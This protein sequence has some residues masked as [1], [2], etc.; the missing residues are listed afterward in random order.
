MA[1]RSSTRRGLTALAVAATVSAL[2]PPTGSAAAAANPWTGVDTASA[3]RS[4]RPAEVHTDRFAGFTLDRSGMAGA[5]RGS[6]DPE[7]VLPT[8]SG[9]FERFELVD[10]PVMEPGLA[11]RHPE[12]RTYAGRGLDDPTATVRA[13]LT[14]LG[15]HAS[16]RSPRGQ[17]FVD[18]YFHGDQSLYASYYGHDLTAAEPLRETEVKHVARQVEAAATGSAVRLRTYRLALVTDPSYARYFGAENVTAA[19]ASLVNRVAQVYEDETAIRLLL[20][21]ATDKTN[22]NTDAEASRPNGPCGATACF[23]PEDL[24][25]C[26]TGTFVDNITAL[27]QLVG[28]GNYDVGHIAM[29]VRGGGAAAPGVG[30]QD[31]A[32]GCTGL[33][34]P[35]GDFFAVDYVAHEIGHQFGADH[36]FNGDQW[37]CGSGQR[38]AED[39]YEPGSGSSIMAYAGIC[40]QDNLQRHSDPYWS[41]RSLTEITSFTSAAPWSDDEVQNVSLRDFDGTDSFRLTFR[42]HRSAPITHG[43]GYTPETLKAAL[44]SILPAGAEVEV[45]GYGNNTY[46]RPSEVDDTGFQVTFGGTLA[47][48]DVRPLGIETTG[49]TALVGEAVQGGPE[50]NQGHR[51]TTTRNHRPV[52]TTAAHHTIP[53]RTPFALTGRAHDPDGDPVTYMWEQN[54]RGGETGTSL[55]DNRKTNGPL[56]RQ[57]GTAATVTD[58]DALTYYSP[59]ENTA[60]PNPTRV[61]PDLAQI[62]ANNTNAPTGTCPTAPPPPAPETGG[63]TNLSPELIDCYSEFLPTPDWVGITEDRTLHFKLTARDG[64]QGGGGI[65]SADTAL[66]ITPTA[67]P[68]LV[69]SQ[70][71]TPTYK[72]GSRQ[73]V[74]WTVAGTNTT[75]INTTA[76]RITFSTDGGLTFPHTL[77]PRTRND[78]TATVTLP[79]LQTTKGR[80][81]VEAIGNIYFDLNDTDIT[82]TR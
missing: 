69:T 39:S 65:G 6:T 42:G 52:V 27:G 14:P 38:S 18:P 26:R 3:A 58:S 59:G 35:V 75:P 23:L 16:V 64:R 51:V 2:I 63:G 29:G 74:T 55:V 79:R 32:V 9:G 61:F 40:Q 46:N 34:T 5:L 77:S 15:F 50:D 54:D 8:P 13:D 71:S 36:P 1:P 31:K 78:G 10:T 62:A 33:T 57:F 30:G 49:T 17:W 81:R 70:T 53:T 7:V 21:D 43:P 45:A 80:I 82:I 73:T 66:T 44:T 12:I 60:T 47:G 28:A 76:V 22:L 68:F 19:K 72:A 20:V 11:A 41:H 4:D 37:N 25:S 48:V 67:G 24:E 56:F